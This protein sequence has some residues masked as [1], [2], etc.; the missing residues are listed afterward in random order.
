MFES[1]DKRVTRRKPLRLV[2]R[3]VMMSGEEPATKQHSYFQ[4]DNSSVDSTHKVNCHAKLDEFDKS[5]NKYNF[6]DIEKFSLVFTDNSNNSAEMVSANAS[7]TRS[8]NNSPGVTNCSPYNTSACSNDSSTSCGSSDVDF[9]A[10][11]HIQTRRG[12]KQISNSTPH[13]ENQRNCRMH[14]PLEHSPVINM[15]MDV[16]QDPHESFSSHFSLI[17]GTPDYLTGSEHMVISGQMDS[18]HLAEGDESLSDN[19]TAGI[20]TRSVAKKLDARP[21]HRKLSKAFH[22]QALPG[23]ESYVDCDIDSA[24]ENDIALD[25][26]HV[27]FARASLAQLF[28]NQPQFDSNLYSKGDS[29]ETFDDQS[30]SALIEK[31]VENHPIDQKRLPESF[32]SLSVLSD[33]LLVYNNIECP[34]VH[35]NELAGNSM[36]SH[37]VS[38]NDSINLFSDSTDH[39]NETHDGYQINSSSIKSPCTTR[40]TDIYLSAKSSVDNITSDEEG[41]DVTKYLLAENSSFPDFESD[42]NSSVDSGESD[43]SDRLSNVSTR[44][45]IQGSLN[46]THDMSH[47]LRARVCT[48]M[49]YKKSPH[50]HQELFCHVVDDLNDTSNSLQV[51]IICLF[52]NILKIN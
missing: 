40:D 19:S 35:H 49:S 34:I 30:R 1:F 7:G 8:H 45:D 15:S 44:C 20:V 46:G 14:V 51:C 23:I 18:L 3:V 24:S 33:N 22:R 52:L 4:K 37:S 29:Y 26:S 50:Y 10:L 6:S 42:F 25:N 21:V 41:L 11:S 31:S 47:R 9:H 5:A 43:F 27:I 28:K 16:S 48:D 17:T 12:T 32:V 2:N 13:V 36:S 38:N 39:D